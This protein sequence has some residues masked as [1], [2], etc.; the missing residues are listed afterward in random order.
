MTARPP[1]NRR[2]A[3][4]MPNAMP[5]LLLLALLA[6]LS[7]TETAQAAQPTT[8]SVGAVPGDLADRIEEARSRLET[9]PRN[10]TLLAELSA[11]AWQLADE[12]ETFEATEDERGAESA[13][14]Y[15]RTLPPGILRQTRQAV[16]AH[17]IHAAQALATMERLGILAK[18][19]PKAAC[20]HYALAASR[21]MPSALFRHAECLIDADDPAAL[22]ILREGATAGHATAQHYLGELLLRQDSA[23]QEEAAH[24]LYRA[25]RQGRPSSQAL[26]A[27]MYKEGTGVIQDAEAAAALYRQSADLGYAIAENNLGELYENGSG[28]ARD[29]GRAASLY[30]MAAD[31][32]FPPAQLNLARLFALGLGV[33]RDACAAVRWTQRALENDFQPARDTAAWLENA[34]IRCEN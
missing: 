1:S 11:L 4:G 8:P 31:K 32:G 20:E 16:K 24:W 22:T 26:L 27:W 2:I 21:Q 34:G 12:L 3:P 5:L 10:K 15:L 13:A 14:E 28:V 23:A 18:K 17:D 7:A 6:P 29:P 33:D 30:K 19:D 25:S 9:D